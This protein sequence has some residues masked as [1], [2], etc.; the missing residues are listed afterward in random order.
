MRWLSPGHEAAGRVELRGALVMRA[1]WSPV[2]SPDAKAKRARLRE[3]LGASGAE[4]PSV[5]ELAQLAGA[6]S[7][8]LLR[9]LERDGE[10]VQVESER[11]YAAAAV[12][13]M[14]ATLRAKMDPGRG[15]TPAE[16]R[17]LLGLSR[18]FLIPL[19]EY[20]DRKGITVRQGSERVLGASGK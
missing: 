4:P 19:L 16:L 8:P 20:C 7:V 1:G 12:E 3:I 6:E 10:V 9:L 13:A 11:Y 18:K 2:L 5:G 17:D 14:V 15:Y